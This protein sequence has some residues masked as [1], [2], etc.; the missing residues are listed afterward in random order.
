MPHRHSKSV[1]TKIPA[2]LYCEKKD[3]MRLHLAEEVFPPVLNSAHQD[4]GQDK[5]QKNKIAGTSSL[6]GPISRRNDNIPELLGQRKLF[7]NPLVQDGTRPN[8]ILPTALQPRLADQRLI[9]VDNHYYEYVV[10]HM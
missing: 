10:T 2:Q 9:S 3:G 5:L 6:R 1:P 7:N 4:Q 8:F